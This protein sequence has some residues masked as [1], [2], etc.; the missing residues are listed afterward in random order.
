M[1]AGERMKHLRRSRKAETSG[2]QAR[3]LKVSKQ[4]VEQPSSELIQER[5]R[6]NGRSRHWGMPAS[7]L[8]ETALFASTFSKSSI[9][10]YQGSIDFQIILQLRL[11]E[12]TDQ[13][14]RLIEIRSGLPIERLRHWE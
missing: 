12:G 14:L 11:T 13:Y 10:R 4:R 8:P 3:T 7:P 5:I 6:P 9:R 1:P 2:G